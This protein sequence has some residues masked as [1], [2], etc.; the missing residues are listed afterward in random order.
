MVPILIA[1][2]CSKGKWEEMCEQAF[3]STG[4]LITGSRAMEQAEVSVLF[5]SLVTTHGCLCTYNAKQRQAHF[6][7]GMM[8]SKEVGLS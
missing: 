7:F 5:E 8:R 6:L 2:V 1:V 3:M 4:F